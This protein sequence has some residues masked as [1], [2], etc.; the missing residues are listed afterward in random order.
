MYQ[1]ESWIP[2]WLSPEPQTGPG[3]DACDKLIITKSNRCQQRGRFW[4][5]MTQMSDRIHLIRGSNRTSKY[6]TKPTLI[7][8]ILLPILFTLSEWT[9][10]QSILM[11]LVLRCLGGFPLDFYRHL[12]QREKELNKWSYLNKIPKGIN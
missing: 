11:D 12:A 9:I 3:T 1:T 7:A 6:R 5:S 8:P 2:Q 10:I 4:F